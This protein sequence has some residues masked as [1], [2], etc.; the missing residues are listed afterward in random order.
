MAL[1]SPSSPAFRLIT[2]PIVGVAAALVTLVAGGGAAT[3]VLVAI[4]VTFGLFVA[5]GWL[6]LWPMDGEQTRRNAGREDYPHR[7][8]ELVVVVGSLGTLVGIGALLIARGT[9]AGWFPAAMAL[10]GVF[11]AWASLHLMYAAR[12]AYIYYTDTPVGGIDFNSDAPATYADFLYF[13]YN[14]GM[15]YQVS[16]TN[17]SNARIRSV[18]LRQCLLSYIFGAVILATTINLVAGM[19]TG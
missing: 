13:S 7:V 5:I 6:V 19:F 1:M 18:V 16:D 11:L 3:A 14:L 9:D 8:D 12:Y 4:A 10:L 2:S 17:V 15:T